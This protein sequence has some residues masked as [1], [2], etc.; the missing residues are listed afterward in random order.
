MAAL[1]SLTAS[2]GNVDEI[3]AR[4]VAARGGAAKLAAVE[5]LR[6]TAK[7]TGPGGREAILVREVKRPGLI[8]L[9]FTSQ[10]ITGVYA[11]DGSQGW[12]VSP[13][14][15]ELEPRPMP[16]ESTR[17]AIAQADIGGPLVDWKAKGHRVELAGQEPLDGRKTWKLRVTL[18]N[19]DVQ[20][21]YLDAKSFLQ[22]RTEAT[23]EQRGRKVETET[24]FADYREAGGVM[25]PHSIEIGVKGRPS[26]LSIVVQKIEVNP[27]LDDARFRMPEATN[28]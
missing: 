26:R 11:Y 6:M 8:R 25:F 19:A 9:E 18:K 17:L 2:A 3:V 28:R 10:G 1:P 27:P 12:Q 24:S 13:F 5:S 4:H 7:A 21:V 20:Q 16:A 23:R 14:D 15:G 22:V